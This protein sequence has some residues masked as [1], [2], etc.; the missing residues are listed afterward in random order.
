MPLEVQ[1]QCVHNFLFHYDLAP[2]SHGFSPSYFPNPTSPISHNLPPPIAQCTRHRKAQNSLSPYRLPKSP[3][4]AFLGVPYML[5]LRSPSNP[6]KL[7]SRRQEY[8]DI[9][10]TLLNHVFPIEYIRKLNWLAQE[11]Q[12]SKI[13][14]FLNRTNKEIEVVGPRVPEVQNQ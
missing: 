11:L 9:W 7:G 3:P 12:R 14:D 8:M 4:P 1:L 13:N 5:P 2:I 10:I 6:F